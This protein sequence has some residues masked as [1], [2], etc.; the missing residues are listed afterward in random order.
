[1]PYFQVILYVTTNSCVGT[2]SILPTLIKAEEVTREYIFSTNA[3]KKEKEGEQ[4][5]IQV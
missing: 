3:Q 1:M 4:L 2:I 5:L